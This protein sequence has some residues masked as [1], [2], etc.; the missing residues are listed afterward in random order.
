[1]G[2]LSHLTASNSDLTCCVLIIDNLVV[3]PLTPVLPDGSAV[4]SFL[5]SNGAACAYT[6]RD[7]C[8]VFPGSLVLFQG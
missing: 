1:M 2:A 6:S 8:L 3:Q 5:S 4:R 7:Q